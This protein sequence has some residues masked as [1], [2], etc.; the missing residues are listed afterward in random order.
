VTSRRRF[1]IFAAAGIAL[2]AAG[3][4][5]LAG[6]MTDI[7]GAI[8]KS[9]APKPAPAQQS[10]PAPAQDTQQ[11]APSGGGAAIAYQ[12]QFGAFYSGF[13]SMGWFGYKDGNYKPG[14]GTIWKFTGTGR[15]SSEPVT[16]ERALLKT[17]A[18]GSQWWRF[19]L[20]SGK[21]PILYEFLVAPDAS[22]TKV[23]YKDPDS[24]TVGE[25]VPSQNNQMP[26]AAPSNMPKSRAEMAKYKVDRQTVK[27]EAGSF[28][29]DH[30]AYQDDSGEGAAES[31]VSSSV[32]GSI[33]KSVYTRSKDKRTSTVEL[34]QIESGVT[35]VLGSF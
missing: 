2:L 18:D 22:V 33:V 31:W 28:P 4:L 32:P 3:V 12:Y 23:R 29:S 35:T 11:Q 15:S 14:Q 16:F 25:F 10:E 19:K 1:S 13:W 26:S 9:V 17:N 8:G 7:A 21:K 5:L 34:I 24:G 27:V 20:D 6:C 30:Y